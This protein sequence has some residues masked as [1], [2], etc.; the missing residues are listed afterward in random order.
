MLQSVLKFQGPGPEAINGRVAMLAFLGV[1]AAEA[2]T[3]RTFLEQAASPA[4]AAS[5]IALMAAVTAASLA[6]ALLGKAP[7]DRTFPSVN[8]SY[9]NTQL[10][11]IWTAVSSSGGCG[12]PPPL[13]CWLS[14]PV[15]A[16]P[17]PRHNHALPG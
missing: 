2:S 16:L 17:R 4:G 15:P 6:P 3:G 7:V 1:A 5:A 9:P 12:M 14:V 11:Y 13:A 10:P 8:D